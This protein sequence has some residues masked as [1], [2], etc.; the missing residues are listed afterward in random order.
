[1]PR[2]GNHKV[3][4]AVFDG[5][6]SSLYALHHAEFGVAPLELLEE[7][8]RPAPPS[9]DLGR[10]RPGRFRTPAGDRSAAE[11]SDRHQRREDAFVDDLAHEL[12]HQA[13]ENMFDEL[14]VMAPGPLINRF[15]T[16]APMAAQ[17]ILASAAG[18]Y[19]RLPVK[20]LETNVNALISKMK[21]LDNQL[22]T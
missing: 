4:I 11:A 10:D 3:R 2:A 1:M 17:R 14:I 8:Y 16:E 18:D 12:E 13:R 22:P 6:R 9:R 19:T 20:T 5:A 21:H 15:K 7:R